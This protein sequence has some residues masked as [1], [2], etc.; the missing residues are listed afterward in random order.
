MVTPENVQPM[1]KNLLD[2]L[3]RNNINLLTTRREL[4]EIWDKEFHDKP[5]LKLTEQQHIAIDKKR[6]KEEE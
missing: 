3:Q 1:F 6:K 2:N 4:S 5:M